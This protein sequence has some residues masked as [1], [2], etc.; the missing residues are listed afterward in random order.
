MRE[1]TVNKE[2][3]AQGA[4]YYDSEGRVHE[5]RARAVV[6]ACNGIGTPRLLLNSRSSLFPEGLANSS[7][8][9][10]KNLMF[11]PSA[12]L[13]GVFEERLDTYKGPHGTPILSQQFYETDPNLDFVRGCQWMIIRAPNGPLSV[14]YGGR[15]GRGVP[16]GP[17]HHKTFKERFARCISINVLC[18]DLPE[19]HNQV[20]LDPDMTDSS[21][22]PAPR[23]KYV[24]SENSYKMLDHGIARAK[25]VLE[26]AGA[27][28]VLIERQM[29]AGGWHLMGTAR[30]GDHTR[31]SV[32]DR[33]GTAHDVPNLFIVDGSVFVTSAAVNPTS[34]IQALALRT[35]N[36]LK[37]EGRYLVTGR[38]S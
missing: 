34:T 30:M 18:E 3:L 26:A 29:W 23:V 28:E 35:A 36:Y 31:T 6:I 14:A 37:S 24:V 21:G 38:K 5:Q 32:V 25:D 13:T 2:G 20:V 1:I 10:G 8:L 33:W 9:L 11:H 15:L 17:Q 27:T 4:I 12:M 22:I 16:W 19:E 7:G